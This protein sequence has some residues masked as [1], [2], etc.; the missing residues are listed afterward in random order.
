[1]AD[2]EFVVVAM[3]RVESSR[4]ATIDD[5]WDAVSTR[6]RLDATRVGPEAVRGLGEFS[7]VE[8]VYLFDRVD[9]AAVCSGARRPRG[10]PAWPEV[11]ILA[12]RAP[13]TDRTAWASPSA[14]SSASTSRTGS[15]WT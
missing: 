8:V 4:D 7:H 5:G 13:R 14:G 6:I 2:N 10:N 1:M 15:S 3:G 12:Q 11:G 9:P